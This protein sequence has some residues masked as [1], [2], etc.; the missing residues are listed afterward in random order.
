MLL[1]CHVHNRACTYETF[2]HCLKWARA[3][4]QLGERGV[5]GGWA[6]LAVRGQP[7]HYRAVQIERLWRWGL[8][9]RKQGSHLWRPGNVRV[10]LCVWGS[11]IGH[12]AVNA[13]IL[14]SHG[15]HQPASPL[16]SQ[17]RLCCTLFP[18][19]ARVRSRGVM[20]DFSLKKIVHAVKFLH[21]TTLN[22]QFWKTTQH[23]KYW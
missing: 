8:S 16:A 3:H 15:I 20:H 23:N 4:P 2:I 9:G 14:H 6:F 12:K 18:L 1:P 22:N 7:S 17:S 19:W 21:F 13:I 10:C 11:A 5:G